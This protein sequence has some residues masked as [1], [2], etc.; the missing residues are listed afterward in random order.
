MKINLQFKEDLNP[1]AY[2]VDIVSKL[3]SHFL[4]QVAVFQTVYLLCKRV[5]LNLKR[6]RNVL[7]YIST[8]LL[9]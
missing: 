2:I 8:W 7:I 9:S 6:R 5:V 1:G 3:E 4:G